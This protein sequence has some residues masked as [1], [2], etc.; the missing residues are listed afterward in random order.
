MK[1]SFYLGSFVSTVIVSAISQRFIVNVSWN[2]AFLVG[3]LLA[4]VSCLI[5]YTPCLIFDYR[6]KK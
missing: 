5:V 1:K 6:S 4:L 3:T 2:K